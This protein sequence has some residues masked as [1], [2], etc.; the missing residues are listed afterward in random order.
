[1]TP[2]HLAAIRASIERDAETEAANWPLSRERERL[3]IALAQ[4]VAKASKLPPGV[5]FA[6]AA[7]APAT[8]AGA[9]A[10]EV[11]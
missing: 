8:D 1:M 6:L 3:Y 2:Q 9:E 7:L 11:E 4:E 10:G 5:W